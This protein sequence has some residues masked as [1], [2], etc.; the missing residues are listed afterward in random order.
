MGE[1]IEINGHS[2]WVDDRGSGDETV[3]LL[4]GGMSNSDELSGVLAEPLLERYR[5]VAS[6]RRAHGY[7]ADAGG[8]FHYV[9][10]AG[11]TIGVLDQVVGGRGAP[12]RVE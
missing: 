10:M 4:H 5:V 12:D 9:D 11:E 7:T 6:D 8:P 1:R 3:L 2:T